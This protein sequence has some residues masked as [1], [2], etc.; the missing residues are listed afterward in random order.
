MD[1]L[2]TIAKRGCLVANTVKRALDLT[3]VVNL[4]LQEVLLFAFR[5]QL[6]RV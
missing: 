1:K 2:V 3:I 6:P 5:V 4:L